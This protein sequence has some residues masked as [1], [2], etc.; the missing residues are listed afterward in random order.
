MP[1]YDYKCP[2]C[3][4]KEIDV[5]RWNT[6]LE[7]AEHCPKCGIAMVRLFPKNTHVEID[8]TFD[9]KDV[10]KTIQEKNEKLKEKNAGM[11]YESESIKNKTMRIAQEKGII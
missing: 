11:S 4:H 3:A 10:G 1:L 5:F 7:S 9:S 8:G 6:N 2:K